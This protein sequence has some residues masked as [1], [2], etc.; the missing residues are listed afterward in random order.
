MPQRVTSV[1][2]Y[3]ARHVF[4]GTV[5][6]A[7]ITRYVSDRY[8]DCATVPGKKHFSNTWFINSIY[9][10]YLYIAITIYFSK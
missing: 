10:C 1:F 3:C 8:S 7:Q 6:V 9:Y 2:A 4:G 5:Q